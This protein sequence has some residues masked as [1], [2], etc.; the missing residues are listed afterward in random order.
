MA[1]GDFVEANLDFFLQ[2]ARPE[3]PNTFNPPFD[4]TAMGAAAENRPVMGSF[5]IAPDEALIV[6]VEPPEGLYWSYSI[7][8]PWWETIDYARHQSSLNGH[9][10]VIDDDGVLRV[11][12]AHSDPGLANWLDTAGHS[13]GPVI[14]RCVRTEMPTVPTTRVVKMADVIAS[15]PA[16]TRRITREERA[17]V[18]DGPQARGQPPVRAVTLDPDDIEAAAREQTGLSDFGD[19][20]YREGLERLVASMNAEADLT[21]MGEMMQH[22]RL[23]AHLAARLGVEDVYRRHPDIEE[24]NIEGPVFV[25]GLPRT[26]TTALSQLVAADPQFRSLRLWESSAPVPPPETATEHTDPRIAATEVG[27][28]MMN[29]AFPLMQSLYH[30]EATAATECQDLMGMS[31]RTMHFDGSARVPSYLAWVVDCDMHGTYEY[32][33]RVLRLLQWRCPPHLWHLK[34]PVHMFALDALL[35]TYPNARFLWSHRDPAQ[36]LGSVCSLIHYTRSWS[37][38]RDDTTE[39]GPEMTARWSEAVR[40]AMDF[41]ARVGDERFADI[42]FASLQTDPVTAVA[43]GYR[44]V[45]LNFSDESRAAVTSWAGRHEPGS[46]GTHTYALT[47]FGIDPDEVRKQFATYIETFG[48]AD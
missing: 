10:A 46:S 37:S 41:R 31:F 24:Q 27:L 19:D 6:E 14:L 30:S 40:R 15:V 22:G 12:I 48:A 36:V 5:Q 18:M 16:G 8:N 42:A 4:G 43:E 3:S 35:D 44:R 32:H 1:L 26:G 28:A 17:A 47:D 20:Y 7:G 38:D 25:I 39:L 21:E 9:Q 29:E 45:G 23:T 33:R 2:F 34:T 11:V 13:E